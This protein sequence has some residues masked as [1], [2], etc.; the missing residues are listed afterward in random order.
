MS[1]YHYKAR[2]KFGKLLSGEMSADS[3]NAVVVRL[4]QLGCVPVSIKKADERA[5]LAN[6]FD[7]FSSVKFSELNMFTRQLATLQKAGLPI[8]ASL[9]ALKDQTPNVT[10]KEILAQIIR[11]IESGL[12]FS[13][14]LEKFPQLFN[15]L[16]VNMVSS[17]ETGG[18]MAEVLERLALL[19]EYEQKVKQR[20]NAAT[21]Y[22][23]MV[24]I[25]MI[26]GFIVLTT[27]VIPR[28]A[29][30]Y[31]Q[32]SA[33]LP[34]PTLV[35]LGIYYVLS[36]FWWLVILFVIGLGVGFRLFVK[37]PQ[38]RWAWDNFK[39]K[40]PVFGPL[41]LKLAMSRFTRI[42]GTLMHSGIPLLKILDI[43]SGSTGNAVIAR[44]IVKI[45]DDI[46]EGRGM[47]EQ[48]KLSGLF[49]TVVTQMVAVGEETGKLDQL[50]IHV[51]GYYDED[52][53]Y[54]ISNLTSLIE[55][56]LIVI[57]GCCVLFMALGIF[58]P[59]WNMMS[60]FRR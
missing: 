22:P 55:P 12:S 6:F 11:D 40:I 43:A 37:T 56:I 48:M 33:K 5:R 54:M 42:T 28:Y 14:A 44:T 1:I 53:E 36:H 7:R 57:L 38:G 13:K 60:L 39:L 51:S 32:F 10:F 29:M 23:L 30:I 15:V 41:M 8:L 19:G 17:G 47:S 4:N 46:A 58:L 21:R 34:F 18:Q 27:L 24:V 31:S 2:D 3:E 45:K 59:M 35:L 52:V 16:Y 50:L 9:A 25:A 20:I 26:V 49:P